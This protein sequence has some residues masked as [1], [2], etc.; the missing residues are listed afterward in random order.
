M[1]ENNRIVSESKLNI[2]VQALKNALFNE[3]EY[4]SV[5]GDMDDGISVTVSNNDNIDVIE[6]VDFE[7]I[8]YMM[9][10]KHN[11]RK[12]YRDLVRRLKTQHIKIEDLKDNFITPT[13][14]EN[15]KKTDF[16]LM[17]EQDL[18]DI[19]NDKYV[20][21]NYHSERHRALGKTTSLAYLS[22]KYDIPIILSNPTMKKIVE[23]DF[24]EARLIDFSK[25]ERGVL[26]EDI[27]LVDEL[28]PDEFYEVQQTG[29]KFLGFVRY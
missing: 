8:D 10:S 25:F 6:Y 16:L 15:I 12:F 29:V 14:L 5:D 4:V 26:K 3:F 9:P 27:V 22:M 1:K 19:L 17:L 21:K 23:R 18:Q 13:N 11:A 28:N 2:V 24:P 20:G 7:D